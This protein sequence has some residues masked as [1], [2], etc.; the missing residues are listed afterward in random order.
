VTTTIAA[1]GD[2]YQRNNKERLGNKEVTTTIAATGNL[3]KR[4]N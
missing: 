3:C 4:Y 2:L 1:A